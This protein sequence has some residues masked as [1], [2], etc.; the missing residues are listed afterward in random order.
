MVG[1]IQCLREDERSIEGLAVRLVIAMIVGVA[2]L[3]VMMVRVSG[4][5]GLAVTEVDV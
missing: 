5:S 2:S 1:R 3:C 4:I